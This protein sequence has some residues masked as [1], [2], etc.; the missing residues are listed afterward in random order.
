MPNVPT[1]QRI[2]MITAQPA[3][4]REYTHRS[5]SSEAVTE[6]PSDFVHTVHALTLH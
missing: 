6:P 4:R 2:P 5:Q 1:V 3:P